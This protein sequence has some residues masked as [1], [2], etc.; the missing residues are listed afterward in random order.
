MGATGIVYKAV[1][2]KLWPTTNNGGVTEATD[3]A[4]EARR[5][6]V[7]WVSRYNDAAGIAQ[8]MAYL[9]HDCDPPVI[10][11][12]VKSNNILLDSNLDARI[13]DFGLARLMLRKNEIVSMVAGNQEPFY[14]LI[15]RST[16]TSK[17]K[18]VLT[19]E[20]TTAAA[21]NARDNNGHAMQ[22]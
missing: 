5:L 19:V 1:M 4:G 14:G 17:K 18:G 10:H 3:I 2:K 15:K 9:H 11:C 22:T 8:G 16:S 12:D 13:A 6:L 7:D 20:S 21:A